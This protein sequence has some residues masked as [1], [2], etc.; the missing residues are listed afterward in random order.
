M[1]TEARESDHLDPELCELSAG[2]HYSA[3]E[4]IMYRVFPEARKKKKTLQILL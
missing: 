4:M 3:V 2:V 1:L